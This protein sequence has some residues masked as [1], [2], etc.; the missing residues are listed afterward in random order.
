[1]LFYTKNDFIIKLKN[2]YIKYPKMTTYIPVA[3]IVQ[4]SDIENSSNQIEA[5]NVVEAVNVAEAVQIIDTDLDNSFIPTRNEFI[6]IKILST[7]FM[8]ISILPFII[9][10]FYYVSND[11]TCQKYIGKNIHLSISNWLTICGICEIISL[12]FPLFILYSSTTL[13]E[14]E[15]KIKRSQSP[16]FSFFAFIWI[17]LGYVLYWSEIPYHDC[18]KSLNDYITTKLI[19]GIIANLF[20][21]YYWYLRKNNRNRID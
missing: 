16:I 18:S 19:I 21:H 8:F 17:I 11:I 15:E 6:C 13:N 10:D 20:H 1:M 3:S 9:F 4:S 7:I 14:Y 12:I 2:S 5:V